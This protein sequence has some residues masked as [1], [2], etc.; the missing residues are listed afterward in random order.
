MAGGDGGRYRTP[1]PPTTDPDGHDDAVVGLDFHR[2]GI[3][4]TSGLE[5][6]RSVKI[7]TTAE[8]RERARAS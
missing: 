2:D 1:P 4:A 5:R 8:Y 6:D 7:W 3:L